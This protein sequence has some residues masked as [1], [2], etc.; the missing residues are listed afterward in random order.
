MKI[1]Q[2][3]ETIRPHLI[4]KPGGELIYRCLGCQAEHS[5]ESLL[6]TCPDCGQVLLIHDR[7]F[8]RL[9]ALSGETWQQILDYR[10][11]L[12]IPALKGIYRYHEFIGPVIPLDSVVYLGEGHTPVV[13]ANT[14][15]QEKAGMRFFY[16]NDGQNP[17]AS[18]KDRGMA[19]ALSYI[20]FLIQE[21]IIDEVLSIC[22]S[23]GDTSAAAALY[24][25][26]LKPDI[27][28]AVLLPHRKVTPQQ[29]S[30]PLGSGADVFEIPGVFD[31]C[32]KVVEALADGYNVA[33]LNSKN[34]WRILGQ[35]SYSYE[36][37]QDFDYAMA[38]KVVVVPI[39]N[40]GN[41]TAVMNG[42]LKFFDVGIIDALP[43]IVG[44]QS[45]HAN[46]VYHYYSQP[47]DGGRHFVP[48][49]VKPSVAQAAMIGNPVSMPR[50]IHLVDRYNRVAGE[51]RVFFAQV[52]EQAIMD[53]QLTANRNGHI[54]CTHGGESLAGLEEALKNGWVNAKET[55][56]IDSTAHALKFSGFQDMYFQDSFPEGFAVQPK[57]ALVNQPRYVCPAHL[58]RVP[59]PGKPMAK[60]DFATFVEAVAGQI[61]GDLGLKKR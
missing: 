20:H 51:P 11:M 30:Q 19:S 58:K 14:V 8:D 27:K 61:A 34:A 36:I 48:M 9:K 38:D 35:E 47:A 42:F 23:T 49:T 6:Y 25:A 29:L 57:P 53:W 56:I 10:R 26:Y 39:G 28:S 40:A 60:E 18:F 1:D 55:A 50:V 4:P 52:T 33:L 13:E 45:E 41:I 24:A 5:I 31:D 7:R 2:F 3:P 59:E 44:V 12:K 37:A 54:A 16:K 15:L 17:S 32:M 22:A 46:P 21:G 43:K